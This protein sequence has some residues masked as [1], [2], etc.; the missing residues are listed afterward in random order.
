MYS[1]LRAGL[2]AIALL[3]LLLSASLVGGR[4]A[5]AAAPQPPGPDRY[6]VVTQEYTNYIWWLARW[7]NSEVACQIEVDH[8][9]L[10][11]GDEIYAACGKSLYDKWIATQPCA[12][13]ATDPGTCSGYYLH[14]AA[15]EPAT[16]LGAAALPPPVVWVRLKGCI[17]YA[18]SYRCEGLPTLVLTGEE[19]LAGY[20]ITG[21]EGTVG[22]KPFTCDPVCQVDLAPTGAEGL[23][24]K[25]WAYSSYGDSSQSFQARVRVNSLGNPRD[26]SWY[27]DV[28]SPQWRGAPQAACALGWNVFPPLGGLTGW[29]ASPDTSGEL[30]SNIPYEYLAGNLIS[31]GAVDASACADGGLLENGYASVCGS[32]A[33]RPAVEEWQNRFDAL[34]FQ[35]AQEAGVPAQLLKNLFSRESQFWPGVTPQRPEAGLG[36]LTDNG[37]DTALLWNRPFYEQFCPSV[38]DN[39]ACRAGYPHLTDKQRAALRSALVRS[40][41]AFCPDCPLGIDLDEAENSVSIF[42]ETL[43][44]NCS[45]A[46]MVIDLNYPNPKPPPSYEDLWRFTLANYNAG[47]G[48]LGLAVNA[49]ARAG[50]SLDWEHVASHLTPVCSGALDYVNNISADSP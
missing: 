28:L 37:A 14:F 16:R 39:S 6:E 44:A 19:P 36:Q 29:L 49:T 1:S 41:D 43:L 20:S 40:V 18:S 25:F 50:Q 24:I 27:V 13:S 5:S 21:L 46:G 42:A 23:L 9:G 35:A 2:A 15:S 22:D 34:I 17:P 48:C 4:E 33:A 31:H 47:P 11:T 10:P 45:Q 8:E 12:A 3:I 7:S 30:A 32:E 38:L 26:P